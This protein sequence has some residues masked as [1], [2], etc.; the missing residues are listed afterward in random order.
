[1]GELRENGT[2]LGLFL[3]CMALGALAGPPISGAIQAARGSFDLVGVW[4]GKYPFNV[5]YL[6]RVCA[7]IS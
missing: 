2:R 4:A 6:A 1:M 3:T 7:S 5:L